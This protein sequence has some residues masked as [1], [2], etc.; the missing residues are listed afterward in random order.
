MITPGCNKSPNDSEATMRNSDSGVLSKR[1]SDSAFTVI[2]NIPR[3][4]LAELNLPDDYVAE[5]NYVIPEKAHL[6]AKQNAL[7]EVREPVVGPDANQNVG[8]FRGHVLL[9]G[10]TGLNDWHVSCYTVYWDFVASRTTYWHYSYG[11]GYYSTISAPTVPGPC[12]GGDNVGPR[13][14][15]LIEDASSHFKFSIEPVYLCPA[16]WTLNLHW[17]PGIGLGD[18]ESACNILPE[19]AN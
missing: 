6:V 9:D 7:R 8:Q 11:A 19:C 14:R 15:I 2:L 4:K 1:A 5:P 12:Y 13:Y 17:L 18:W 3:E 10:T 16:L